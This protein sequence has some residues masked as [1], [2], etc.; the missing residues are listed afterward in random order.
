MS[1]HYKRTVIILSVVCLIAVAVM[2]TALLWPESTGEF[3]PPEFEENAEYATPDPDSSLGYGKIY[4]EGM[5]FCAMLCSKIECKENNAVLY[6]TNPAENTVWMKLRITDEEGN[7][8]GESGVLRPGEYVKYVQLEKDIYE[9]TPVK[10]KIITY[11]P[12]T[13]YSNG[14]VTVNSTLLK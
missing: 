11:E 12:E 9:D 4:R 10:L 1:F 6:F 14:T 3:I 2:L 5:N 8:L 13:Y 7:I